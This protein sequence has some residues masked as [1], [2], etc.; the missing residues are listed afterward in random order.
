MAE[1][2]RRGLRFH[3]A[4]LLAIAVVA[5]LF[6]AARLPQASSGERARLAAGYRF[7][8][9]PIAEPAGFPLH[10]LRQVNPSYRHIQAWISSVGAG[11]AMADLD[12]DGL[13]D[14]LCSV[15]PRIDQVVVASAPVGPGRYAAFALDL[16]VL[17][18]DPATIAPMGCLAGDFNEDGRMD[19]LVYF[20]GRTPVLYLARA[21]HPTMDAARYEAVELI[22]PS[23]RGR[24]D[25]G[26]RWYTNAA[27]QTDLDG[28]G[29]E[30]LVVGNYFPDG[31]RVLDASRSGDVTMQHSMSRAFNGGR[32]RLL[33]WA[34]ASAGGEPTVRFEEAHGVLDEQVARGWTLAV[35]AADLDGDL[36]PELYLANDFGPDRLLHNESTPG[37]LRFRLLRGRRTPFTPASKVLGNDSFKGMGVDFGDLN[38]DGRLDLFVSNITEPYALEESNFAWVSTGA[39]TTM[40]QG[41]APYADRSERLGLARSGWGW[42]DRLADLN[43]DGRLDALQATGFVNGTVNRWPEL[44]ELAMGN[45]QLLQHLGSWPRFTAG[46]DLSG[47]GGTRLFAQGSDGRFVEVGAMAGFDQAVVSRGIA[48]GDVDGDG[49]LDVAVAN[50][51]APPAFYRNDSPALGGSLGLRLLLP[52]AGGGWR[53]AIGAQATLHRNDGRV[54]VEQV[55]G[56]SGHSGKRSPELLF[57]LGDEPWTTYRIDLAWRDST[58]RPHRQTLWLPPGRHIVG[59][60]GVAMEVRG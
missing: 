25:T 41:V 20:W 4:R 11:I 7:T 23:H 59:L 32:D 57:G 54:L 33:R 45:D 48:L 38:G 22:P 55:D 18:Y 19:L 43:N 39:V 42:D 47:H 35:G 51:W 13:A 46:A 14:D 8:R 29:H 30:D 5:S 21:G 31:S 50:Q 24:S 26:E 16:E 2:L 12:G 17:P 49:D 60:S 37:R 44:Q 52:T 15:D 3:L 10:D 27:T 34:S 6:A 40:R 58:G 28:D 36:L 9:L 1:L 53:P 56:G